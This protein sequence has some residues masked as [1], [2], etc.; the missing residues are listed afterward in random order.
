MDPIISSALVSGV[1][2]LAGNF[3]TNR[4]SRR[5]SARANEAALNNMREQH[6]FL[7]TEGEKAREF[8]SAQIGRQFEYNT[9][10]AKKNRDW[11]KMMSSTAVQRYYNDLRAAGLNPILAAG[12]NMAPMGSGS[13]ASGN[14]ASISGVS[15][16]SAAPVIAAEEQ[17]EDFGVSAALREKKARLERTLIETTGKRARAE[18]DK[19]KTQAQLEKTLLHSLKQDKGFLLQWLNDKTGGSSVANDIY[20]ILGTTFD[21]INE[22][23]GKD[24]IPKNYKDGIKLKKIKKLK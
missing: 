9:Q 17:Y 24:D 4:S 12:G 15:G 1:S 3:F 7:S 23:F 10:E 11:Q 18:A 21:V 2:K 20:R 19:A 14:A 13:S 6:T 22:K 5:N 8:N 16:G